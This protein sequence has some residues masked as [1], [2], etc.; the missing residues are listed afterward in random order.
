[1]DAITS[2]GPGLSGRVVLR[3]RWSD[4]V[5]MH[6]R[7]DPSEIAPLMPVGIV[8]DVFD[9]STWVGLIPFRM[10]QTRIGGLLPVPYFGDFVEINV[11]LYGV[12]R[13]GRRGVVF[14]SLEASRFAAVV[15]ARVA[16]SLPYMWASASVS[17]A[18]DVIHYRSRRILPNRPTTEISVCVTSAAVEGDA[19]ADFLTA[20]FWLFETRLGST[21][22]MPN[23]HERW[24]LMR[25]EVLSLRDELIAAS[26]VSS[27]ARRMPESVLFSPGVTTFF[28][29]PERASK[30]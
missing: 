18:A 2:D 21:I 20:R 8:P 25:A 9:G 5:F 7:A 1:M 17:R 16:F 10:S 11:R 4:L 3:Q 13:L 19:L 28:G 30:Q 23:D 14:L 24:P 12:D 22:A 29:A 15:G 6:W 27:I 26:G